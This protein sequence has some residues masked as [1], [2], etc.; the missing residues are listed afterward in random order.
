MPAELDALLDQ[1]SALLR[2]RDAAGALVL[3]THA[4]A[5]HDKHADCHAMLGVAYRMNEQWDEAETAYRR[6]IALSPAHARAHNNLADVLRIRGD[7][8]GALDAVQASL[9]IDSV[10]LDALRNLAAIQHALRDYAAAAAAVREAQRLAPQD[11]RLHLTLARI[12]HDAANYREASAAYLAFLVK[13]PDHVDALTDLGLI[14][15]H[16]NM[17]EMALESFKKALS[18]APD[19]TPAQFGLAQARANLTP[20]WHIPMMNEPKRNLAYRDAIR[21]AVKPGDL[22][23]EIGS[24]AGLLAMLAA[25][26][27]AERVVSCEMVKEVADEA[28]AI[29]AQNGFAD[30]VSIVSAHSRDLKV[31]EHLPRRADVLVSE[32]LADD[33]VGEGVLPSL[34]D[35]IDR[36]ITPEAR[37]VPARGAAMAALVGG[38]HMAYL[39]DLDKACGFDVRSF[40]KFKPWRQ[41]VPGRIAYEA[42][43]DEFALLEY[44]FNDVSS[45][46]PVD[47]KCDV[48][49]VAPGRC[50]GVLQWLRLE[51]A[52]DVIYEN[53]PRDT[54]SVWNK[55]LYSFPE[56]LD[57]IPGDTVSIRVWQHEDYLFVTKA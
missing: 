13:E 42:Y 41:A 54:V 3:L 32:I 56:P 57:V 16:R 4:A 33:F 44:N 27:G 23:L 6:A 19:H 40:A 26:A 51:L 20:P 35:A 30:R 47:K 38:E 39:L 7:Y 37:I 50:Y 48:R 36:L 43:S 9:K 8:S 17:D 24:G 21:Q 1:A 45:L 12:E 49:I 29:V 11:H 25:E 22:V 18:L 28:R 34:T 5:R 53:H 2:R 31:G 55:T 46:Q 52:P 14:Y 10:N 15:I